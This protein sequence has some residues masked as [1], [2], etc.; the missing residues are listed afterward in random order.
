MGPGGSGGG[1]GGAA[2]DFL[3][4]MPE[5]FSLVGHRSRITQLVLH[6]AYTV[7]A[8]A[9]DDASIRFWDYDSGEHE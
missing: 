6:P 4:R 1:S 2:G 3:P 8:T 5:R 9:S 7:V